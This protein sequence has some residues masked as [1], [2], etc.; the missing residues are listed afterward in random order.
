M[1]LTKLTTNIL[2]NKSFVSA[3]SNLSHRY[4]LLKRAPLVTTAKS[5]LH[6]NGKEKSSPKLPEL[7]YFPHVTRWL[8]TKLR[9][10]YLQKTWDPDFSEGAFIFGTTQALCRITEIINANRLQDLKNLVKPSVERKL[11]EDVE[12]KL[13]SMQKEMIQLRPEDIKLL[14][15]LQ[16]KF[17]TGDGRRICNVLLKSL[18]LK[19]HESPKNLKLVL[20]ILEAAFERD[21]SNVPNEWIISDFDIQ[22]CSIVAT[23]PS[24]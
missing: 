14:V 3:R 10:K 21:Y 8:K 19:W 11:K 5:N 17:E 12:V 4:H 18:S 16:V 1:Q 24:F 6:S 22:Q 13:T 9:F 2:K 23:K 7:F 20:I 15:P